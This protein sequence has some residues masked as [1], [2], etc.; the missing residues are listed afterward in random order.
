VTSIAVMPWS[1]ATTQDSL[2]NL[3]AWFG[4]A[5]DQAA[6][7][8]LNPIIVAVFARSL[9]NDPYRL[10]W[11]VVGYGLGWL[12]GTA[13]APFLQRITMR[14]M[15][16]IVGGFIVRTAA[17][18]LMTFAV[19]DDASN[20]SQRFQ[21]ILICYVAYAIATGIARTAQARH[22]ILGSP[23]TLWDTHS[24]PATLGAA[25]V[26]GVAALTM[27][28]AMA[29]RALS[30]I[31]AFGRIWILASVALGVATLAA[32]REGVEMPEVSADHLR[33]ASDEGR[34]TGHPVSASSAA[35]IAGLTA[36]TF[37]ETI[38]FLLMFDEFRRQTVYLRGGL[39]FFAIGWVVGRLYWGA[40]RQQLNRVVIAQSAVGCAAIGVIVATATPELSK[41]DWF[42][43][44]IRGH[45]SVALLIYS[46]GL[47]I[48]AGVSVQRLALADLFD[49]RPDR[50]RWPALAVSAVACLSPLVVGW[51]G[52]QAR[53]AWVLV[54]GIVLAMVVMAILGTF[55]GAPARQ[56]PVRPASSPSGQALVSRR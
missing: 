34:S 6:G 52:N 56:R 7:I 20:S 37:V 32:I 53:T 11:L 17:I 47:L 38:A 22:V 2:W 24:L 25:A 1:R 43:D 16:W 50:D 4:R 44:T 8:L 10:S 39:A 41:A 40:I 13:I 31:D 21:S 54:G 27:W 12:L 46:V 35:V 45:A 48:G 26:A 14:V 29:T 5:C 51:I 28:S 30:W 18:V 42:P 23:H 49:A 19:T 15:P 9:E 3:F 33:A 55:S 36:L